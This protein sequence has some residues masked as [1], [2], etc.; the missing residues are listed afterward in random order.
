MLKKLLDCYSQS[1]FLQGVV[2]AAEGGAIG[3]L[4]R[5]PL[6]PNALTGAGMRSLGVAAL[7]GGGIAVRNW[8]LDNIKTKQLTADVGASIAER[9][10]LQYNLTTQQ[11]KTDV[12]VEE[13]K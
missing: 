3:A 7:A 12:A 2:R 8:I 1:A 5:L 10:W 9:N 6:T 11:I 4:L 13:K